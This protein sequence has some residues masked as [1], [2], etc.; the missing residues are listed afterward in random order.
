MELWNQRWELT[1]KHDATKH[2]WQQYNEAKAR[3]KLNICRADL[4]LL[5]RAFTGQNFLL[6]HQSKI[7]TTISKFCR[8]CE[9]EEETFIHLIKECPSL[10]LTRRDIFLDKRIGRDMEW[11]IRKVLEFAQYPV[12]FNM[13]KSKKNTTR[14]RNYTLSSQLFIQRLRIKLKNS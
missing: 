4:S 8:L 13:L 10:E 12:I 7:D 5:V 2:F 3:G 1:P 11:S 9:E 14:K 6:Y